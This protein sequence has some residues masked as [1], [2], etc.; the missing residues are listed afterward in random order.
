MENLLAAFRYKDIVIAS[1][2]IKR[3]VS[4]ELTIDDLLAY[5]ES[6]RVII[7]KCPVCGS[8]LREFRVNTSSCN[9]VGEGLKI[10]RI[11]HK[12]DYEEFE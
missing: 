12:C 9:Q 6:K 8:V 10:Q 2:I 7:R 4:V 5:I 11:C 1:Q 3:L